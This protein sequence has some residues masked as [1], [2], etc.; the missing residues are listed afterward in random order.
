MLAQNEVC[1][2]IKEV[3]VADAA[4]SL[5]KMQFIAVNYNSPGKYPCDVVLHKQFSPELKALIEG[6]GLGGRTAR[7]ILR[8]L[9]P[10]QSIPP[11]V[12]QWMPAEAQWRRFQVPLTSHPDIVMR[13]PNDGVELHLAP[14]FLYEVRF[15]R[16][17]EVVHNAD[18][19]RV[20]LQ[21]DQIDATI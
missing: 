5:G 3:A 7:A 20:H 18:V 11:H 10:R 15:D 4:A 17:H 8:K 21:I 6:L 1:K 16:L 9:M 13:W 2:C 14:G 19:A 12:D